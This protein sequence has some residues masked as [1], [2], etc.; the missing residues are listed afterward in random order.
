MGLTGLEPVTLM[1]ALA[2]AAQ[3]A[4]GQEAIDVS[5]TAQLRDICL[6]AARVLGWKEGAGVN[7]S[8]NTQVAIV[9]PEQQAE[10][11]DKLARYHERLKQSEPERL[12]IDRALREQQ[13]RARAR[14]TTVALPEPERVSTPAEKPKAE[15]AYLTRTIPQAEWEQRRRAHVREVLREPWDS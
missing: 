10:M 7:V 3:K 15:D 11:Q 2:K 4:G 13:A 12:E 5:N 8:V 14:E 6:A 9:T 1:T